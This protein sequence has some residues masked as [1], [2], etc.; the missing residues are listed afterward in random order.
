MSWW[1]LRV[2]TK[3][4]SSVWLAERKWSIW[5][6]EAPA[7]PPPGSLCLSGS[8]CRSCWGPRCRPRHCRPAAAP[9]CLAA[10]PRWPRS[11]STRSVRTSCD[12]QIIFSVTS[13]LSACS[14]GWRDP[15]ACARPV[16]AILNSGLQIL[17][18]TPP[19]HKCQYI[20]SPATSVQ[21]FLPEVALP[22]PGPDVGHVLLPQ[23]ALH[24]VILRPGLD[25]DGVH[26]KL[27]SQNK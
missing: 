25:A 10:P 16:P 14:P 11:G 3:D 24:P 9:C 1:H 13:M 23:H 12:K 21:L 4:L 18:V 20:T 7:L 15:L 5:L 2:S 19:A 22:A 17:P 27:P 8:P 6:I 26:T